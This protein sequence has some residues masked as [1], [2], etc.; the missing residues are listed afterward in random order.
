MVSGYASWHFHIGKEILGS[1]NFRLQSIAAEAT[2]MQ[3]VTI[4][5]LGPHVVCQ[6]EQVRDADRDTGISRYRFPVLCSTIISFGIGNRGRADLKKSATVLARPAG[7]PFELGS[8]LSLTACPGRK[9]L[10]YGAS[11]G[12]SNANCALPLPLLAHGHSTSGSAPST[13]PHRAI[14]TPFV[15]FAF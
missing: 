8:N 11:H 3:P 14:M 4:G 6:G 10:K 9:W 15:P 13:G 5:R 7:D 2:I 12:R 1:I